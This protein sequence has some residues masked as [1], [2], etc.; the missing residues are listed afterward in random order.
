V[1][2]D[3]V[4]PNAQYK[5]RA[6]SAGGASGSSADFFTITGIAAQPTTVPSIVQPTIAMNAPT[7]SAPSTNLLQN[8]SF[9]VDAAADSV[10]GWT[11]SMRPDALA[12]FAR[13]QSTA[14]DGTT[15]ARIDVAQSTPINWYV[16]LSQA[17]LPA[18]H[19]KSYMLSF[20]ARASAPR[21]IS[22]VL[23]RDSAPWSE[24]FSAEANLTTEWKQYSFPF[25]SSVDDDQMALRLNLAQAVGQIWIDAVA[26]AETQLAQQPPPTPIPPTSQPIDSSTPL[27]NGQTGNWHMIFRDEFNDP[28][29][30]QSKWV[31]CYLYVWDNVGCYKT[32][33]TSSSWYMPDDVLV[34]DGVLKLRAQQRTVMGGDGNSYAYTS[35][36]ISSGK[37]TYDPAVAPR[38][39]FQYGYVEMRAKIPAGQGF[40]SAFW[41]L[42]ANGQWPWEIDILEAL[43]NQPNSAYFNVHYP[44]PNWDDDANPGGYSGPDFTADFHT[45]AVEWAPDKIVWYIDGVERKRVTDPAQIPNAPMYLLANLQ[46]GG[47]W[48]G[49]PNATTPLPANLEIDYIR[50]WQHEK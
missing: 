30:E 40:W 14:S 13:D 2:N 22:V 11:F 44:T 16:Q 33:G 36:I 24:Y 9:E 49:S 29:L 19:G 18:Q 32:S 41:M 35:G 38:F 27:P 15:A 26:Y 50:V 43:G 25:I 48:P 46:V 31:R 17:G 21:P 42:Q 10:P 34:S 12:G 39:A 4:P 1:P 23:Q 7:S 8:G 37:D 45:Y 28:A 47:D 3:R 5:I 20:W 6:V